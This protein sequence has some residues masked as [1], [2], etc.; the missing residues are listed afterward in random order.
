MTY[1]KTQY[2]NGRIALQ[3]FDE[4]GFPESRLTVN[5]PEE[6]CKKDETF[7]DINNNPDVFE[8]LEALKIPFQEIGF[9]ISGF[10]I[11]P[12]IKLL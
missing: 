6:S 7:L 10:C 3:T 5:L 1:L 4:D 9:G 11:Y 2:S 8:Q 12:K